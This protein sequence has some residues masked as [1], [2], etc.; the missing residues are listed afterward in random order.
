MNILLACGFFFF[1]TCEFFVCLF[2]WW[3]F[4][5]FSIGGTLVSEN[6]LVT[7]LPLQLFSPV[8]QEFD[9][10]VNSSSVWYHSEAIMP[11]AAFAVWLFVTDSISLL[12]PCHS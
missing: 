10:D 4:P 2:F 8:R 11:W 5:G 3:H 9:V 6:E 7:F 1:V 12:V